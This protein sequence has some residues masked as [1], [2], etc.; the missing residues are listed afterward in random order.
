MDVEVIGPEGQSPTLFYVPPTLCSSTEKMLAI[1]NSRFTAVKF[2][3]TFMVWSESQKGW[4]KI[5]KQR[6]GE[7]MRETSL[8]TQYDPTGNSP[9]I[10]WQEFKL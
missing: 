10:S 7:Y 5:T 2:P 1:V 9:D 4:Y 8:R 3:D 6:Y